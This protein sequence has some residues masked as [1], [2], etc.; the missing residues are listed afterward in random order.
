M[1]CIHYWVIETADGPV[2]E[3]QCQKCGDIREFH[4]AIVTETMRDQQTATTEETS[5]IL[6]LDGLVQ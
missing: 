1:N 4:N 6:Q 5:R 3:G 2:S